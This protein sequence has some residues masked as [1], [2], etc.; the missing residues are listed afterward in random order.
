MLDHSQPIKLY[1]PHT[2]S[3]AIAG[4]QDTLN[5][6]GITSEM[7]KIARAQNLLGADRDLFNSGADT[8]S[9]KTSL[10]MTV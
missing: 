10:A 4:L 5:S 3:M 6:S 1:K 2:V 9:S 8:M 7:D